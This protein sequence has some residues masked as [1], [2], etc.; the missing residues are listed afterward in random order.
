MLQSKFLSLSKTLPTTKVSAAVQNKSDLCELEIDIFELNFWYQVHICVF[1]SCNFF[2]T[3]S[4]T[5]SF[6][7]RAF[8]QKQRNESHRHKINEW[9]TIL[10]LF[11]PHPSPSKDIYSCIT[12]LI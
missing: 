1:A 6:R 4:R 3:S 7:Y 5:Y 2:Q 9:K 10:L 11:Q 12:H 8:I